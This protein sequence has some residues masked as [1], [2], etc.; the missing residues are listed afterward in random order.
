[1]NETRSPTLIV[2]SSG[3]GRASMIMMVWGKVC[4]A[5]VGDDGAA[6][7]QALAAMAASVIPAIE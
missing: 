7:P 3:T 2:T 6:D 1:M 5:V 4:A